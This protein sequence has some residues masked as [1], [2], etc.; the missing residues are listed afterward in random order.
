MWRIGN[1]CNSSD[2]YLSRTRAK[3]LMS[4][5]SAPFLCVSIFF[6]TP[7]EL[8]ND[9]LNSNTICSESEDEDPGK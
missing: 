1:Y 4:F 3:E 9:V 2:P 6:Y 8:K 5:F 7:L